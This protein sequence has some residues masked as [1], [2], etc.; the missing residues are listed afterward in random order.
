MLRVGKTHAAPDRLYLPRDA[1]G[2]DGLGAR[3]SQ[4]GGI[5]EKL[6]GPQSKGGPRA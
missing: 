4:R 3:S 1:G 6:T 5:L 2:G